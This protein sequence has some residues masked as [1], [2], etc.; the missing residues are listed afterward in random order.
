MVTVHDP[1]PLALAA[2]EGAAAFPGRDAATRLVGDLLTSRDGRDGA[3]VAAIDLSGRRQTIAE[4][5]AASDAIA[6]RLDGAAG[7]VTVTM[8]N[9][10][11]AFAAVFGVLRSRHALAMLHPDLPAA[12][13]ESTIARLRPVWEIGLDEDS[14]V[15]RPGSAGEAARLWAPP[16]TCR[17]LG[18]ALCVPTSGS[19]GAPRVIGAPHRQVLSAVSRIAARLCYRPGDIVAAVPPLSFDYGLYQLLLA[20]AAGATVLLDPRIA[21]AHGMARAIAKAGVTVLPLVPPMLRAVTAAPVTRRV[22]TSRVR[23]VTTTGDVLT[24]ADIAA[25]RERFPRARIV[26]MYGLSECK[27][28]AIAVAGEPRPAGAVGLALDGTDVAVTADGAARAAPGVAGELVVAGPHLTLGYLGDPA[29]TARRFAIDRRSGLRILRTGDRLRQDDDGWLYWVG[30]GSDVIKTSGYR[31]D[32]AELET[33]AAA[34]GVVAESGA[35]GRPDGQR[36]QV[37][38]LVLRLADGVGRQQGREAVRQALR[39][40]IPAWA[41]PEIDIADQPLPRTHHG[42]INRAALAATGDARA[43]GPAPGGGTDYG[44][45]G[46][47]RPFPADLTGSLP[48]PRQLINCHTQAFLSAYT[49]P[50]HMTTAEY[51]LI[52]TVPFGVRCYPD[53]PHRLLIP[54]LDPDVGLDRASRIL[55]LP[56]ETRWH[57]P[58]A[59]E[60]AVARLGRWLRTG[61]VVLGPV[62]LG[63]L[64]YQWVADTLQGCDHYLVVLGRAPSGAFIVRDPE[65]FVQAEIDPEGLLDAWRAAEVR[66]G[67]GSFTLRRLRPRGIADRRPSA[68]IVRDVCGFALENLLA[69]G[70][71]ATAGPAAY[72][73]LSGLSFDASRR[74]SLSVQLPVVAYRYALG[75]R[76]ARFGATGRSGP[77]GRVW[78]RLESLLSGQAA[79]LARVHGRLG[80]AASV[81]SGF[82][83][84]AEAE[85]EIVTCATELKGLISG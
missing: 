58:S 27:R 50:Y 62:D 56:A 78:D 25:A 36:G 20:M 12:V 64:P 40:R 30:R 45:A 41:S 75:A 42:K 29:S 55:G 23:L 72:R 52:T 8:P 3:A 31:L 80:A 59:A 71:T 18:I 14:V 22:D 85:R 67:R 51:E 11:E 7:V 37:P 9:R 66:E 46:S 17:E 1:G 70:R 5:A 6:A 60:A 68:D 81:P 13:R 74:R 38:V 53:D 4:L 24:E 21:S 77:Q 54:Y 49:L 84:A 28:V 76:L 47:S 35:F 10:I 63:R 39:Q 26:P 82:D 15:V 33:A 61:P 2:A 32:P 44:P 16:E 43:R 83:E 34:S 65:G 79:R 19:T 73:A 69:S 57:K 48:V